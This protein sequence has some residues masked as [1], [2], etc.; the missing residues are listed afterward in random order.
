MVHIP[1]YNT[2]QLPDGPPQLQLQPA[3]RTL[4]NNIYTQCKYAMDKLNFHWPD[5]ISCDKFPNDSCIATG[6][7]RATLQRKC[8]KGTTLSS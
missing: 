3:C 5:Q 8:D 2:S 6:K 1:W 4:C 7:C